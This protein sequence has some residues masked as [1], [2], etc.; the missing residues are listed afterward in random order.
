M[1][2][3]G[4]PSLNTIEGTTELKR[5]LPGAI[6][7]A[8][9]G[10]GRHPKRMGHGETVAVLVEHRDMRGVL[11]RR[12]AV[13][14]RHA[15]FH[16]ALDLVGHLPGVG[17]RHQPPERHLDE[18]GIADMGILVDGGALHGLADDP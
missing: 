12:T 4:L 3:T 10:R 17:L 1:M 14:A 16:A 9:P 18:F 15:G 8:R 7:P 2:S 11:G 5:A 13:E 6:E